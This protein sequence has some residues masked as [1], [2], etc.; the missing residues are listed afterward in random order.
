MN[1]N[2][3]Y[4][5][6]GKNYSTPNRPCSSCEKDNDD[7]QEFYDIALDDL[8]NYLLICLQ[9]NGDLPKVLEEYIV[10]DFG[11]F[12]IVLEDKDICKTVFE[13]VRDIDTKEN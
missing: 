4:G 3:K 9:Q 5:F 12:H 11:D 6:G 10:R 2:Y 8:Y 7:Y 13:V 1:D